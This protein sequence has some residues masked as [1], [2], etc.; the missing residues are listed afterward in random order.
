MIELGDRKL[1]TGLSKLVMI[2]SGVSEY[3]EI[4]TDRATHLAGENGLGKTSIL[5]TLQFL[6]IDNWKNMKF[7]MDQ[8][9]TEEHYF[10]HD[11][12][13]IIFEIKTP[14]KSTHMVIFRGNNV[15]DDKRY[16]RFY[17]DGDYDKALF[18]DSDN[19]AMEWEDVFVNM[20]N[21]G[22]EITPLKSPIELRNKLRALRWLPTKDKENVHNDF[23]TLMKTLNTLGKVRENDLKQVLLNINSGI[24]TRID[25]NVEFGDSWHRH[26][27]RRKLVSTFDENATQIG[28]LDRLF[29]SLD[30][31]K[32]M[33][34]ELCDKCG[35]SVA[36]FNSD[37]E[38]IK[39]D[40]TLRISEVEQTKKDLD[41]NVMK[42][43][44]SHDKGERKKTELNIR[45]SDAKRELE[46]VEKH[47][48]NSLEKNAENTRKEY[49]ELESAFNKSQN[50]N[51][52]LQQINS[53][54][55][56]IGQEI[57]NDKR[58]LDSESTT[59]LF[60]IMSN[61]FGNNELALS[62]L[63]RN[64]LKSEGKIIDKNEF[65]NFVKR[66]EQSKDGNGMKFN[67]LEI[68]DVNQFIRKIN[69]D[70]TILKSKITDNESR[71]KE[72]VK[73][74]LIATE[75]EKQEAALKEKKVKMEEA[76][77]NLSR[78]KSWNLIGLTEYE[79]NIEIRKKQLVLNDEVFESLQT[80][81]KRSEKIGA[82]L[83]SMRKE[84][85]ELQTKID[86]INRNWTE[87]ADELATGFAYGQ[88]EEMEIMDLILE[89]QRGL[90]I[91]KLI[92]KDQKKFLQSQDILMPQ[93]ADLLPFI[94]RDEFVEQIL[95]LNLAAE[96]QR[97]KIEKEWDHLFDNI[98][99]SAN[100]MRNGIR[101]L[102]QEVN[103]I[104]KIFKG[105][106]VSNLDQFH[107]EFKMNSNN[108]EY[109]SELNSFSKYST[110]AATIQSM[111]RI[112]KEL[113]NRRSIDLADEFRLEFQVRFKGAKRAK[114]VTNLDQ[115]GST[116]TI[117]LIKAVL[118][119][120]LLYKRI[121]TKTGRVPMPFF[122]DEVG[123]FGANN[124]GQ[125]IEVAR[126]LDFQIFTASPDSMEDADVVYPIL[127]GREDDRIVVIPHMAIKQTI[128]IDEEE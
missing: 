101:T 52:T 117:V 27:K 57:S 22:R 44:E 34:S 75:R 46:W 66:I 108:L 73:L 21:Q 45:I 31:N 76:Q 19:I 7:V 71:L 78:F 30:S 89:L 62:Y 2:N 110:D 121:Q 6:M 118:L 124:K 25:F 37:F 126:N 106:Q 128:E 105:I 47:N 119:M 103:G 54:E 49:T 84:I 53:E 116:G 4:D 85:T 61:G 122:L 88:K 99:R 48:E 64:L 28:T 68:D 14:D 82:D 97:E 98:S 1:R 72:L 41:L 83:L 65:A 79:S 115:A 32:S 69:E 100:L 39:T 125:I 59:L 92:R 26:L 111:E 20:S 18:I 96:E 13:S 5:S 70:P 3:V 35:P 120:V 113:V 112:G 33:L 16:S 91:A 63:S 87:I 114:I 17:A 11:R 60:D 86:D 104:N 102:K 127:G 94:S 93:F 90:A 80:E 77:S 42:L 55:Y 40:K 109:F 56:R 8:P 12:S 107:V 81:R 23:V 24:Q 74:K 58:Q 67:G 38:Q 123:V 29:Q 15:A 10:P 51:L 9:D 50:V 95:D 43:K 36:F